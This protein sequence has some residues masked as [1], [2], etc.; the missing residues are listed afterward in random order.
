MFLTSSGKWIHLAFLITSALNKTTETLKQELFNRIYAN[1]HTLKN[2]HISTFN[3]LWLCTDT[4]PSSSENIISVSCRPRAGKMDQNICLTMPSNV[5]SL[6]MHLCTQL[7]KV[8]VALTSK[9]YATHH[10]WKLISI[11]SMTAK[12]ILDQ[13]WI[14]NPFSNKKILVSN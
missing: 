11:N 5:P 7:W 2:S 4:I 8:Y 6:P 13:I 14:A 3:S 10:I 9:L 1:K 12:R